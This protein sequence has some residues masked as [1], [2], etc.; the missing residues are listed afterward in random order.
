MNDVSDMDLLRRYAGQHSEAAFA[1]LVSRHVNLVYSAALRKTANPDLAE[2]ITQDVFVILARK[3][4][5]IPEKTILP[6]WLYQTARLTASSFLKR[7]ARRVRREEEASMQTELAPDETWTQL[8]PLLEDAMG[9]LREKERAVVVLRFFGNKSFV[10]AAKISGLSDNA[11]QKQVHRA[12]EKMHR[13]LAKRGVSS[14]TA[15]IAGAISTNSVHAA[16]AALAKSVTAVAIAKGAAASGSAL[17]L[18][19]GALKIMAWTKAKTAILVGVVVVLGAGTTTPIIIHHYR[20]SASAGPK[21]NVALGPMPSREYMPDPLAR[22][23]A[24][25]M[26]KW[27]QDLRASDAQKLN[28]AGKVLFSWE[29]LQEAYPDLARL[30]DDYTEQRRIGIVEAFSKQAKPIPDRL[31]MHHTPDTVEIERMGRGQYRTVISSK[32]GIEH[33]YLEI[34]MPL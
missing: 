26:R 25:D 31:A 24:G 30:A 5:R 20:A 33:A 14:T 28:N 10:E 2:E 16:P 32:E 13:Y 23:A 11:V 1:A 7:E 6:G 18:I 27:V 22:R 34:S 17:T 19:K 3:A 21:G 8:A 9:Q 4:G 15:F 29:Q 12:L